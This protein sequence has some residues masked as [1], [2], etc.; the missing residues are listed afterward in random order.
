[1]TTKNLAFLAHDMHKDK[2]L[3]Q[4]KLVL[5]NIKQTLENPQTSI[6]AAA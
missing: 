5:E 6:R 1:M 3:E 2:K 4:E